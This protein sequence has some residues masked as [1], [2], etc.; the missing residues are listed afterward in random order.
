MERPAR[1]LGLEEVF[2]FDSKG[3]RVRVRSFVS[4][5]SRGRIQNSAKTCH[6]VMVGLGS[7]LGVPVRY[8]F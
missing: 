6:G 1:G 5:D 4:N 8:S 2:V 7:G 3:G